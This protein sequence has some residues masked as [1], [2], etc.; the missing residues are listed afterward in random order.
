[1]G[2][3]EELEKELSIAQKQIDEAPKDTPAELMDA[4][5]EEYDSVSFELNNLYDDDE[6]DE[7]Q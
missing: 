7:E 5:R 3:R 6:I 1:M 2:R 4:L